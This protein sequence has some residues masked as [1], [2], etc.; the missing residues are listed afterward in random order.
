MM[1]ENRRCAKASF[2]NFLFTTL[3]VASSKPFSLYFPIFHILC[4]IGILFDHLWWDIVLSPLFCFLIDVWSILPFSLFLFILRCPVSRLFL[5]C[6]WILPLYW[7][8]IPPYLQPGFLSKDR[9]FLNNTHLI[10]SLYSVSFD[11]FYAPFLI[12]LYSIRFL[13]KVGLK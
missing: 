12:V 2:F 4:G 10:W 3:T 9:K 8:L 5:L 6:S 1:I 13:K 11:N 7:K